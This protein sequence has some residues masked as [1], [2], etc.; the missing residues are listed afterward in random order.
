MIRYINYD[1]FFDSVNGIII[2]NMY[3]GYLKHQQLKV[4]AN[5]KINYILSQD[6]D[7]S[8]L[9]HD[10][11]KSVDFLTISKEAENIECIYNLS[12]LIISFF[13]S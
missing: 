10:V 9:N 1:D 4:I 11:F 6:N 8:Y 5:N 7:L 12:N 13:S 3:D 2:D